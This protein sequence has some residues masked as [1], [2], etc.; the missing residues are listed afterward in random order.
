MP[1]WR[2]SEAPYARRSVVLDAVSERRLKASRIRIEHR[3]RDRLC[4]DIVCACGREFDVDAE[5]DGDIQSSIEAAWP[6][7]HR[8]CAERVSAKR[9]A[10]RLQATELVEPGPVRRAT[11]AQIR[12][13]WRD[14][15]IREFLTTFYVPARQHGE[16]SVPNVI[17][18]IFP[19]GTVFRGGT[20]LAPNEVLVRW[21]DTR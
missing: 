21:P 14:P 20:A 11:S 18:A 15:F 16:S 1:D 2:T 10:A 4:F 19:D 12:T 17:G 13:L 7:A 5:A 8:G 6:R 3:H 9:E